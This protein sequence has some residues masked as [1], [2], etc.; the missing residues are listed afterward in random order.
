MYLGKQHYSQRYPFQSDYRLISLSNFE[1]RE[2]EKD[3]N[4]IR[5]VHSNP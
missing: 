3:I 4:L 2:R 5:H 1:E